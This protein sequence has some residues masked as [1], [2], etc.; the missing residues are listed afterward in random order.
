MFGEIA[1]DLTESFELSLALRWDQEDRKV[2]NKVPNVAASG[3]NVNTLDPVTFEPGPINPGFL[4]NPG[5]IP[6]RSRTFDQLQPKLTA[7]WSASDNVNLYAS[8]GIGFR[9]GGFNSLG[10]ADLLNLWF[11][12]GF[13]GAGEAVD[14]QLVISDQYDKE[15]STAFE[16]GMKSEWLDS[17]LRV[18]AAVFNTDVDDNQFFEFF[19]G[20]FGIL[21]VVTTIDELNIRGFE[22]D[23]AF[24]ATDVFSV[25]G[26][27]GV[28]DSE[29]EENVNRPLSV[30][31]PVP[32]A[33]ERTYN[34]GAQLDVPIGNRF[35]LF[36]RAD[37]QYVD[38][39][40]F[41]TLQGEQTPNIWQA[42]FFPGITTDFS[43]SKRDAFDTINLRIG[44]EAESWTL[45][46]WARNLTDEE[47]LEE[48][49]PAPEFGGSFLHQAR[50]SS[51][52]ID[53]KYRF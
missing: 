1:Y 41:H 11:N 29:I 10:S 48:V 34:L 50:G 26:G 16:I 39:T 19:A 30:G 36:A 27:I 38:D 46:A 8:Y 13:G 25:F 43:Q 3:L 35:D 37:W 21:R 7:R 47:Y 42:F 20:P 32:Q 15:V 40:W 33:P 18:N 9:S 6:D 28:L 4:A 14:A 52:G 22:A 24:Q 2:K 49:I 45:A 23:V 31:N 51:Y 12:T 17:R 5:G 53:L 44:L